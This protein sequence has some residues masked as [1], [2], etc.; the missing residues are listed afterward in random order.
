MTL[1]F[2][3]TAPEFRRE[4]REFFAEIMTPERREAFA[5]ITG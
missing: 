2:S 3:T 5:A 4:L 1:E